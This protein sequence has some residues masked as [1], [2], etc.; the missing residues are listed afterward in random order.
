MSIH[1][2]QLIQLDCVE[3]EIFRAISENNFFQVAFLSQQS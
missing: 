2:I 3:Q 1:R